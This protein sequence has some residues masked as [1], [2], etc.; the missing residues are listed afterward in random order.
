MTRVL[1]NIGIYLW[2]VTL[3]AIPLNF[4]FM[5]Q[6]ILF[7][8]GINPA[9][10]GFVIIIGIAAVTG[11]LMDFAAQKIVID[12]MKQGQTW[13]RSGILNKAE[14]NYI[15]ALR[16]YDT[17]FFLPFSVKKITRKISGTIARFSLNAD[18]AN[19]HFKLCT[20]V[21]LK[22]NPGDEDIAQLWLGRLR[23]SSMVTSL[24]QE[25]L[26]SLAEKHFA[27][28]LLSV[29]MVDIFLG[30]GRKDFAAKKLY[31]QILKDPL[32]KDRYSKKIED[33]IGKTDKT[34][35]QEVSYF[36]P[37]QESEK[38]LEIRK[39]VQKIADKTVFYL[40]KSIA[41]IRSVSNLLIVSMGR[42]IVYVKKHEK[43]Q[44]YIKAGLIVL[45]SAG[46]LFFMINTM[47]YMF[48]SSWV[49]KEKVQIQIQVPKPFTIQVAA[50]LKQKHALSYVDLLKQKGVDAILKKVDGGGKTWYVVKVSEFADKKSAKA[51]GRE[52]KQKK[53]IDDF[54]VNNK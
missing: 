23:Q 24:E 50:Y 39:K 46:L 27:S 37:A 45:P 36:V 1:R 47:S 43:V 4:Y 28:K 3:I 10:A 48:Q 5:P 49:E 16:I 20:A 33:T 17:F 31:Q 30:L 26:T 41:V 13:E 19:R 38:K 34:L 15:K 21:Y 44:L 29:L 25:V 40:K 51:Y 2:I 7:F 6:L 54:F 11:F 32:L 14:E 53:I 18:V 9:T 22:M 12:L 35:Q 52:L 42:T 8:P